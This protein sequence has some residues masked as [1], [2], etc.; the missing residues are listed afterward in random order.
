MTVALIFFALVLLMAL[1]IAGGLM[2]GLRF[3]RDDQACTDLKP[4]PSR[5]QLLTKL[6]ARTE[7]GVL[8]DRKPGRR[9]KRARRK[10]TRRCLR[11]MRVD[12]L[13]VCSVCRLIGP[14]VDDPE[15]MTKVVRELLRFH[16]LYVRVHVRI[17][18]GTQLAGVGELDRLTTALGHLQQAAYAALPAD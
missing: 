3:P 11:E 15:F 9:L 17:L 13:Q 1:G 2:R 12:F 18:L 16:V 7:P 5:Y 6:M 4:D 14:Y 10:L 8:A